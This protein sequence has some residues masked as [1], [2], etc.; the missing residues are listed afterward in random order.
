MTRP[1]TWIRRL[2]FSPWH[3]LLMPLAL[4]F[5]LPL[6]QMVLTAFMPDSDINRFPPRFIPSRLVLSGFADLFAQ[7][8]ALR[9][10]LNTVIVS[11]IAVLSHLLL[12]SMAGYGFARLKFFG[13]GAGFMVILA[14]IMIPTQLLMIPTYVLFSRIGLIDTLAAAFVPWLASAFGIFLMRQFFLSLPAELEDAA[15]IDGCS[16]FGVFWRVVLP[17]A[18]PA[19]ATLTVFT[20]L[21]S[22]NDLIWPLIA[23]SND[24]LYTIQLGLAN[25]QGTRHT[26]WSLL[27]AGNVVATMPL[28]IA[29]VVAQRQFVATMSFSGL[30][31]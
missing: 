2:P 16:P 15:R 13:R 22:W 8:S 25:F 19:L 17:L 20:L 1:P 28:I 27:M 26:Q 23:I 10:L 6:V 14:T 7:S 3:L 24:Q 12:C 21:G 30:K 5:A 11:A 31:G 4:L 29:F 9:W 18:R